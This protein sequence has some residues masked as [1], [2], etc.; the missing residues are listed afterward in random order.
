MATVVVRYHVEGV[1][2]VAKLTMYGVS[3]LS[4]FEQEGRDCSLLDEI[5]VESSS[6]RGSLH[7][8]RNWTATAP[9]RDLPRSPGNWAWCCQ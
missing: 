9:W 4:I 2:R 6:M 5:H 8:P 3:D 7:R 1:L